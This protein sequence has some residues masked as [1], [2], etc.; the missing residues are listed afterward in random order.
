MKKV[1]LFIIAMLLIICCSCGFFFSSHYFPGT[2]VKTELSDIDIGW[3]S[4][5][6]A[7][8]K[9]HNNIENISYNVVGKNLD[10][11]INLKDIADIDNQMINEFL[12]A[13]SLSF[14]RSFDINISDIVVFDKEKIN[15]FYNDLFK[16]VETINPVDAHI[17]FVGGKYEI[18][19]EVYGNLLSDN[20]FDVF[21]ENIENFSRTINFEDLGLYKEPSIKADN[22]ILNKNLQEYKKYETFNIKY[23]FGNEEETLDINTINDWLVPNYDDNG[24]INAEKP[25]S[26]SHDKVSEYVN[27]LN[28]KYTTLGNTR[29]FKTHDGKTI[30]IKTGDYG[31]WLDVEKMKEDVSQSITELKTGTREAIYKQKG[32]I[33]SDGLDFS[34][35]YV[36][37]SIPKQHI[38]MYVDGEIIVDSDIVTGNVS[39][40]HNT[41]P[42]VFSLTY[43][44]RNAVLRGP[45]YASPVSYWM[46]FDGGIGLHDATWRY[47][48]GGEIYKTN[49]SH[50][51]VNMPLST[52][53]TIYENIESDT[54]IIV[55]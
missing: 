52:A 39:A 19:P 43:K 37:V 5:E 54:P 50:G 6:E 51:C 4:K 49:G 42:G 35:T 25:F 21:D 31:W 18:I 30:E 34:D 38:W 15:M 46:P 24:I 28:K 17:S 48:F 12:P 27:G 26:I 53:K 47:K 40:G 1:I 23:L 11:E 36:E 10:S 3:N 13:P 8:N 29:K 22:E 2:I 9:I 7:V 20:A 14:E 41:R 45:G 55:Y 16:N 33:Y 32:Y 44:T